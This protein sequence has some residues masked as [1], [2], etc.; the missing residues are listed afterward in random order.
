MAEAII[1]SGS[2]QHSLKRVIGRRVLLLFV[3]GD[4]LGA[5]I[6]AL[7][8]KV[9]GYVGGALWLPFLVAFVLAAL[10]A[11]AY[12]ELVGKYPQAAGAALYVNKAFNIPFVTFI[13][14]FAVLMS[15]ITSASAAARAFGGRYLAEFVTLPVIVG[16]FIFLG[17]VTLVNFIGISESVKVN[18]VLTV[19][20]AFGLLVIIAIGVYALLSG[21]GEP[22]RALEFHP[23]NGAFLGVLGGTALAF[24]ALLG[25]EDSVNLAEESKDPQRDFPRALFGG[26]IVAA[27]IYVAVAFTATMLVDTKTLTSSTGP[28][29]EVVKVAGFAFPPKLFALIALLAV[30][31][32]ALINMLMASR[33][34]YG[35]AREG[36]VPKVFAAVHPTRST[37]WVSIVFTVGIAAVLVATGDVGNLADT[38]VLLLLC[39]FTMV[40]V[41]VLILR[42]DRVEH[43][44]FRAPSWMPVLGALVCLVL[45]LPITGRGGDV[46]LRAGVLI[47]IGVILWFVNRLFLSEGEHSS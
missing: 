14:A 2:G 9:A 35:M 32:T 41:A 38:T 12:A 39:V 6:Y 18:V 40:N 37:P 13:V 25:F 15:G 22:A 1:D 31:N 27:V 24:Y 33:L 19:I 28:L 7:V 8:G 29:L 17:L 43:D 20:E 21:Q 5:G 44:H 42:R 26:L 30:G 23:A 46:Y 11:T 3:V 34:V 10:T 47:A 16:A 36:I 45:A 4:I